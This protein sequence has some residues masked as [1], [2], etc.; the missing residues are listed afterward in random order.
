M[1]KNSVIII[2]ATDEQAT[3]VSLFTLAEGNIFNHNPK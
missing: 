1:A 3:C 2:V